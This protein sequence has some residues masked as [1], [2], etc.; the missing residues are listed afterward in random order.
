MSRWYPE[1][2]THW[3]ATKAARMGRYGALGLAAWL[4]I[5]AVISVALGRVQKGLI[6]PIEVLVIAMLVGLS[7]YGAKRF[8]GGQGARIGA[9]LLVVLVLEVAKRLAITFGGTLS[10]GVVDAVVTFMIFFGLLNGV[11]GA[12]ALP[13][14]TPD[15][16]LKD[17]FE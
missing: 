16:D 14:L 13:Q 7:L 10:F 9:V 11:R 2:V 1:I 4:G 17:V 15:E 5:P 3:D 8:A 12:R 6:S